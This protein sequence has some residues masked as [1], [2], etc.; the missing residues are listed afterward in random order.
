MIS[1]PNVEWSDLQG[2]DLPNLDRLFAAVGDRRDGDERRRPAEP[3]R[4]Q[5]RDVRRRAP[6][7]RAARPR[8]ARASASTRTSGATGR[9]RV[10]RLAPA[11]PPGDG[12]V[13]MPINDVIEENDERALRRRGR[14]ARRRA[15]DRGRGT[16]PVIAN[17]DGSDPSTPEERVPPYRRERGRRADDRTTGKVPGGRVD[18]ELLQ[19][20]PTAPFGV[21]L[22]PDEVL[23]AFTEAWHRPRGRAR[24]GLRPRAR[25]RSPD[26]SRPTS[27]RERSCGRARCATPTSSSAGC[28]T[29][30]TRDA[31]RSSW[32]GPAPP[33]RRARRSRR[34]RSARAGF[35]PGLLALDDDAQGRLR[36]H[37]RRRADDPAPATGSTGPRRWKAA[38]WSPRR[39]ERLGE[40]RARSSWTRTTTA[41]SA[42]ARSARR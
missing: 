36:Q 28:S 40:P 23:D 12:L 26:A 29:T 31:T 3:D 7:R 9:R 20:D 34:S 27:R 19:R 17:G 5:L 6:A 37:G 42:T 21:R 41:C 14:A 30:S 39:A 24:G 4:A 15:G 8:R 10:P 18:R 2:V 32:S 13:Y 25:R 33:T 38:G 16:R 22:D 35:E 1:L 11:S